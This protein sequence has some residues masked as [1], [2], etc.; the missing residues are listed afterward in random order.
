MKR[1]YKL[2]KS[3]CTSQCKARAHLLGNC[4]P[5]PAQ[6]LTPVVWSIWE[7]AEGGVLAVRLHMVP[8]LALQW[9]VYTCIWQV[10][11]DCA[12]NV[13]VKCYLAILDRPRVAHSHTQLQAQA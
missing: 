9:Q 6:P 3:N 5:C 1:V 2:V 8:C 7:Q 12:G 10:Q 4:A 13:P 11:P